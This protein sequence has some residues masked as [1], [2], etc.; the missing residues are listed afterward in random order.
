MYRLDLNDLMARAAHD[1]GALLAIGSDAHSTA[2]LEWIRYGIEKA[3]GALRL[4][5]GKIAAGSSPYLSLGDLIKKWPTCCVRREVLF[6]SSG[7]DRLGGLGVTNP[8]VDS[9]IEQAQ[10]AGVLIFTIY[11]LGLGH[12][13]H[14]FWRM[15]WGQNHLAQLTEETGGESYMLGFGP[16]VSFARIYPNTLPTSTP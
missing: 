8:Y 11:T 14:S 1:G 7:V 5:L 12:S 9:A 13:G 10:R 3:A 2:Q 4:P 15:S 16:P 6:I